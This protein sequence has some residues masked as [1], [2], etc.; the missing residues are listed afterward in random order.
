M[1]AAIV[2]LTRLLTFYFF[3]LH[4]CLI[5]AHRPF[6]SVMM[7]VIIVSGLLFMCAV[8]VAM[9]ACCKQERCRCCFAG[10]TCCGPD[11]ELT[12]AGK[13]SNFSKK[14]LNRLTDKGKRRMF[15]AGQ[16]CVVV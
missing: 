6:T 1:A 16:M 14:E 3:V 13:N 8:Y 7:P 10:G 15:V 4:I 11:V 5:V 9:Q 12:A 2:D